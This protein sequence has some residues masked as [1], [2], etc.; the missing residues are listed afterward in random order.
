MVQWSAVGLFIVSVDHAEH[1]LGAVAAAAEQVKGL[2]LSLTD[3]PEVRGA[4]VLST[5]NRVLVLAELAG[6]LEDPE[7]LLRGLLR[8]HGAIAL[9]ESTSV[10][11]DDD[12]VW[13]VFRIASGLESMVTGE[14]EIAGQLKRALADARRDNTA[15]YLVAHLVEEA[16]R[17]S[18]K[19]EVGTGLSAQGRTVVAIGLDL[20]ARRVELA[21]ARV[22]VMG[23]GSYAGASCAQLRSRGVAEILVHSASGRADG[24]ARRHEVS[25]VAQ[26]DLPGVLAGVDLVVTC[27]GNGTPALTSEL[28][29]TALRERARNLQVG[30]LVAL[31]L[32]VSGDVEEP[33]PAGLCV[34]GLE[35][36]RD[37][38]PDSAAAEQGRA[39]QIVADGVRELAVDLERRRL[40]P[41]VV[42][43]RDVLSDLVATELDRLPAEG[44]IPVGKAAQALRR[45]AASMAHIPAARARI[46]SEQ[47]L[48]DRWLNSLTDV[49]GIDVEVDAPFLDLAA[50][51]ATAEAAC[52]VT[53]LRIDDLAPDSSTNLVGQ[54]VE[55]SPK[56]LKPKDL[57]T[58]MKESR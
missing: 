40:S 42:A 37:A 10:L 18:R 4:M 43:L 26:E 29:R 31:D 41:A 48:G 28:A 52:P 32:A 11:S 35:N 7:S 21:G 38:V 39:E 23:T 19:V 47:G 25:A 51:E 46:A 45:L 58:V 9:A 16:L 1:G 8:R 36:I 12:A 13:R 56:H 34:I 20:V 54:G 49:L 17:T 14:R 33:S 57:T 2:G 53:G 30:P 6:G 15:S 24:F 55:E 5:C 27:R 3:A 22:L 50:V 44:E